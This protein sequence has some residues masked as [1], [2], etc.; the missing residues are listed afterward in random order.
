[1]SAPTVAAFSLLGSQGY[2]PCF[3]CLARI[4]K[5]VL[6]ASILPTCPLYTNSG[7]GEREAHINWSMVM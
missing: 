6:S 1:M 2:D 5:A 4:T 3:R 7:C